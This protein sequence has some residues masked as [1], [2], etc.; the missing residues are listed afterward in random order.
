M[1]IEINKNIIP[2]TFEI[3]DYVFTVRYNSEHDYFTIDVARGETLIDGEKILYGKRLF[4]D[5]QYLNIPFNILPV[6]ISDQATRAGFNQL[7]ETV[8]LW[9]VD[10]EI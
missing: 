8:F 9:V 4:S 7:G 10:D 2:Y 6:D 1:I 5:H 3:D